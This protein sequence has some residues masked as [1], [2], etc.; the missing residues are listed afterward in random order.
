MS[1]VIFRF[2]LYRVVTIEC[3]SVTLDLPQIF[4]DPDMTGFGQ[5]VQQEISRVLPAV[6]SSADFQQLWIVLVT[7]LIIFLLDFP[8]TASSFF[9]FD[10]QKQEECK[11]DVC[12]FPT[13]VSRAFGE[14]S[15]FKE[16]TDLLSPLLVRGKL[17]DTWHFDPS[18]ISVA[19]NIED[20]VNGVYFV[21]R[22]GEEGTFGVFKP[23]DEEA[24]GPENQKDRIG[25]V[26]E[27]SPLKSGAYVGDA[28]KKEVAAFLLDHDNVAKVPITKFATVDT[29]VGEPTKMGS[30]Q[31]FVHNDGASED[32]SSNKFSV[33]D[34]HA[35]GLLDTRI[36]NLDR[37]SGNML[38][39]AEGEDASLVPIDHG[40]SLPDYRKMKDINFEWLT[41]KQAS[42][43]FSEEMKEYVKTLDVISDA[44]VLKKLGLRDESIVTYLM[45]STF[46]KETVAAGWTLKMIGEFMQ[47]DMMNDEIPSRFESMVSKYISEYSFQGISF[48]QA[49]VTLLNFLETFKQSCVAIAN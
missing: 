21:K 27:E 12:T 23:A 33:R 8:S 14:A 16:A 43:P 42:V 20:G 3:N 10:E 28:Y 15:K 24:F 6:D 36:C 17:D 31:A 19:S 37:H 48:D 1:A 25:E 32:F 11:Q 39:V 34:V 22:A 38:V 29:R 45:C 44:L 47:R 9:D 49:G 35:I 30:L 13:V 7:L 4:A 26:N 5:Q 40:Y 2:T 46:T 41:W 18:E